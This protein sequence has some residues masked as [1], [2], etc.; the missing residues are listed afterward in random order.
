MDKHKSNKIKE[1]SDTP[2]L[3]ILLRSKKS[4]TPDKYKVSSSYRP[5]HLQLVTINLYTSGKTG[6]LHGRRIAAW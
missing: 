4:G 5:L 2:P 1:N 6:L 3:K